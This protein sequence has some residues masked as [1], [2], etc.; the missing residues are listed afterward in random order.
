MIAAGASLWIA[1]SATDGSVTKTFDWQFDVALAIGHCEVDNVI[2]GDAAT[3][4]ATIHADHLFYDDAVSAEP[5]VAFQAI[6]DADDAGDADG[7]ITLDELTAVDI[8]G[9]ERYQVGSFDI[10]DLGAFVRQQVTTVGHVNGEG[11]CADVEL[12]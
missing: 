12:E 2:D 5:N 6:A 10:E 4:Q 9:F 8:T 1:G 11:H 3:M 7:D